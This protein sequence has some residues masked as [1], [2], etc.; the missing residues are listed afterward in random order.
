MLEI[1][2]MDRPAISELDCCGKL[3]RHQGTNCLEVGFYAHYQVTRLSLA[4][5]LLSTT[6]SK[7]GPISPLCKIST[8]ILNLL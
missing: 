3:W 1:M 8:V 2:K 7:K 4:D 5:F 6:G